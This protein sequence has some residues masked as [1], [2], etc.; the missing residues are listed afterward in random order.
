MQ[1]ET[2]A[3]CVIVKWGNSQELTLPPGT[4]VLKYEESDSKDLKE[5][6]LDYPV[7]S[8]PA[9]WVCH[10]LWGLGKYLE[11]AEEHIFYKF[12]GNGF[13]TGGRRQT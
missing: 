12:K 3:T 13:H 10:P 7:M 5:V 9:T 4:V 11:N 2:S 1:A 8:S 6:P